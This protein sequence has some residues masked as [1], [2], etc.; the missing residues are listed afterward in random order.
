ML[1]KWDTR[2][3]AH[4]NQGGSKKDIYLDLKENGAGRDQKI[5]GSQVNDENKRWCFVVFCNWL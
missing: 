1:K 2:S 5:M 3:K 4:N